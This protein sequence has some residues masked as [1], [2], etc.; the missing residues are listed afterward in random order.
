[1]RVQ[2]RKVVRA[3]YDTGAGVSLLSVP[4]FNTF[5]SMGAVV[6]TTQNHGISVATAG[7]TPLQTP[8]AALC[9]FSVQ[10]I[11]MEGAFVVASNLA[12]DA[13]MGMNIIRKYDMILYPAANK[14]QINQTDSQFAPPELVHIDEVATEMTGWRK[15]QLRVNKPCTIMPGQAQL[16]ACTAIDEDGDRLPPEQDFVASIG[17]APFVHRTGKLGTAKIYVANTSYEELQLARSEVLGDIDNLATEFD[18]VLPVEEQTRG[19]AQVAAAAQVETSPR[20]KLPRHKLLK[21]VD[22]VNRTVPRELRSRYVALLAEY[23]DTISDDKFDLGKTSTVEHDIVLK[24]NTPCY[25]KQFPI[26]EDHIRMIK[27]SVAQWLRL[28][29]VQQTKSPFNSPIF[30]VKKKEGHG[31]RVVLD[32]RRLNEQSMPDLYS[33][34]CV[35]ECI[36]DIGKKRSTI[37]TS[38][39]LTS[40][41]WQMPL[42][43]QARAYTAFT[44]PGLGQFQWVTSPMGLM[45]CPASFAR[46]MDVVMSGHD[47]AITYI[48]DVL[49]HSRTHSDHL[50]HLEDALQRLRHHGLKLNIDKCRFGADS[51]EYLG[52]TLTAIGTK[53]GMDKT[54]TMRELKPPTTVR[55][56]KAVTGLFNYFR[57]YV[58]NFAKIAGPL[59]KLQRQDSGW[60]GGLLPP[61]AL[62]AFHK[63]RQIL[64]SEPILAYPNS[65]GKFHMY[66]DASAGDHK[67]LGGVGVAL[68]QDDPQGQQR[69]VAFAS[70]R[71]KTHEKNYSVFLLELTAACYGID[72]FDQ[73]LRGRHFTVYTDHQPLTRLTK[74]HEKTLNRLQQRM[75]EFSFGIQY[76]HGHQNKVADF[77]SRYEGLNQATVA[78]VTDIRNK[79]VAQRQMEDPEIA[80]VRL[81]LLNGQQP[82][83]RQGV[84]AYKLL[85]DTVVVQNPPRE[86]YLDGSAW[87]IWL[88][89]SMRREALA[90]AHGT[91]IGG[92][93]GIFQTVNRLKERV[94]W[95]GMYSHAGEFITACKVC[96]ATQDK[97]R[98]PRRPAGDIPVPMGPNERIHIDLWGPQKDEERRTR[99]VMVM[100]DAFSKWTQLALLPN[101]EARTVAQALRD[102]WCMIYGVPGVIVSDQGLEFCNQIMTDLCE[103]LGIDKRRTTPYH[104]Q[105]NGQAERFNRTMI[106][107]LAAI[108]NQANQDSVAWTQ[109]LGPLQ[110][111]YNTAVHKATLQPPFRVMFG[112]DPRAPLWDE[113]LQLT[114]EFCNKPADELRHT[115]KA[116]RAVI[117]QQVKANLDKTHDAY[118]KQAELLAGPVP[119][120]KPGQPVW[121]RINAPGNVT[122][123]KLGAKFMEAEIVERKGEFV[124]KVRKLSVRKNKTVIV[125]VDKLK[126]RHADTTDESDSEVSDI[127]EDDDQDDVELLPDARPVTSRPETDKLP[128]EDDGATTESDDER[129]LAASDDESVTSEILDLPASRKAQLAQQIHALLPLPQGHEKMSATELSWALRYQLLEALPLVPFDNKIPSHL[130]EPMFHNTTATRGKGGG[131]TP[132]GPTPP[133][134]RPQRQQDIRTSTEAPRT[135]ARGRS[136]E[137]SGN[138]TPRAPRTRSAHHDLDKQVQGATGQQRSPTSSWADRLRN[139]MRRITPS[140]D[141][142][143]TAKDQTKEQ[144]RIR[145]L[146]SSFRYGAAQVYK[147]KAGPAKTMFMQA[148]E[149]PTLREAYKRLT[150]EDLRN[151]TA[152]TTALKSN[153][154]TVCENIRAQRAREV[155][156]MAFKKAAVDFQ[157]YTGRDKLEKIQESAEQAFFDWTQTAS[158]EMRGDSRLVIPK[159]KFKYAEDTE[160]VFVDWSGYDTMIYNN[161][162]PDG[163]T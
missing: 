94:W 160:N 65:Y 125:N 1:M 127:E 74:M 155:T 89:V 75:N 78:G 69:I 91:L 120:F 47:N 151:K 154:E 135:K 39:D 67:D 102:K 27:D 20:K 14:L 36:A 119:E 90:Q 103:I 31:L 136:T 26:P 62:A 38:L 71:L 68:C 146:P 112:Y 149:H 131:T 134:P 115:L 33:I 117:R 85:Q 98:R 162:P 24:D 110:F 139:S 161:R 100:T 3:L 159:W 141:T 93:A 25:T 45:G 111:S 116:T 142:R 150:S 50:R 12:N 137:R 29:I 114:T 88:P 126:P 10:G 73:L 57:P 97:G 49:I 144:A 163:D 107:Y 158:R 101:K 59:Y 86:G 60:R 156:S 129:S 64:V 2:H 80:Q 92:H 46:L 5:K 18:E 41:F 22:A 70:R 72:T 121:L 53:P 99:Y 9:R 21:I 4:T 104:P 15:G 44:I 7:G 54:R 19:M 42:K 96:Q 43:E 16:V 147:S 23:G 81:Q 32:Y 83:K 82:D 124:Y 28:G 37:F 105:S 6:R 138:N 143:T 95:S 63:L 130:L 145:C 76:I 40:G 8:L 140:K 133:G 58:K 128:S 123:R 61:E 13:I 132:A 113:D 108:L 153:I 118:L 35:E 17:G 30:C 106:R 34:R 79:N 109:Y 148:P 56:V 122:N 55:Q 48:D 52:H 84:T 157:F 51:V 87:R 77:L 66:V 152:A 11:D